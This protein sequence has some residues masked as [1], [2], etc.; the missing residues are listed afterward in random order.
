MK[1]K[2]QVIIIE[3]HNNKE[4]GIPFYQFILKT[5]QNQK[6]ETKNEEK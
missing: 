2:T 5:L 4:I 3:N 6:G 1:R